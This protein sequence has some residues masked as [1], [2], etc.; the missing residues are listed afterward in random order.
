MGHRI[1]QQRRGR[2]T[3]TYRVPEKSF[4]PSIQYK[5]E[6]GKVVDIVRNPLANSPIVEIVYDDNTRGFLIAPEGVRVGDSVEN[7]VKTAAE[8]EEGSVVFA[9]ETYP[10]SGPKLCRSPGSFA[11]I[12]SK[13]KK[14]CTIQ[15]PSK[16][17]KRINLQCRVTL[18]M[19]SGEGIKEKP[20]IKA[21]NKFYKMRARGKLYPRTSGGA[22]NAYDHPFGGGYTGLGKPKSVS[23]NRPPGR[24]VGSLSPKRTGKRK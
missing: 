8:V 10:F 24:K 14:E 3:R 12:V 15:L 21:G 4:K 11:I 22:M 16:K 5:K 20:L 7:F 19:P 1:I 13:T 23:R 9:I 18:G 17:T 2:G 6:L